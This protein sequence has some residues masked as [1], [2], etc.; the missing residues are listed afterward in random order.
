MTTPDPSAADARVSVRPRRRG[1]SPTDMVRSLGIVG[2]GVLGMVAFNLFGQP[3]RPPVTVDIAATVQA[4]RAA[5]EFPTL[6]ATTLTDGVYANTARFTAVSGEVGHANYF[7]GYTDGSDAYLSIEI[8]DATGAER[9]K[10]ADGLTS[11]PAADAIAGIPFDRYTDADET[12]WFHPSSAGEPYAAQIRC[13]QAPVC[14]AV[15]QALSTDGAVA[16]GL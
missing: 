11:A 15:I 9:L 12:V 16:T 10:L 3:D 5:A 14:D 8:S 1:G 4:S 6:A 2:I 13:N 7:I